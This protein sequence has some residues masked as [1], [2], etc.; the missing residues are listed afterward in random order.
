MFFLFVNRLERLEIGMEIVPCTMLSDA[1]LS[2]LVELPVILEEVEIDQS[3]S[4]FT[5]LI[6]VSWVGFLR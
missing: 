2:A 3:F 4:S 1:S 6:S 5:F